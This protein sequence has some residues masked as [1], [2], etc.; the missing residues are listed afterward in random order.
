MKKLFGL[1]FILLSMLPA[2]AGVLENR[3]AE[4]VRN[5]DGVTIKALLAKHA[6]VNAPLPDKS[7]VLSWA[8]DRQNAQSVDM[9]LAAG[10]KPNVVDVD[11][12]SPL[13]SASERGS[14]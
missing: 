7:T 6:A 11:G 9:L 14:P 2:S 13:T 4:A 10:A 8:V 1:G 3:L 12:A 5:N